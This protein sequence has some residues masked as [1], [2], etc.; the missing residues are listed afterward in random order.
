MLHAQSVPFEEIPDV[1]YA[2]D[3]TLDV[4][5]FRQVLIESGLGASRPVDDGSRLQAMLAGANL[6][7][8]ARLAAPDQRVV[9]VAR[10]VTDFSWCCYVAELAVSRAAQ[11]LGIGKRLLDEVRRSVGPRVSI[12]LA[13]MP[14]AVAF[15]ERIGMSRVPDAFLFPRDC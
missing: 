12:V 15:Y 11:R 10:C 8:T 14:D 1:S 4:H 6:V 9:G 7:I 5:A 13:S 3:E 2:V